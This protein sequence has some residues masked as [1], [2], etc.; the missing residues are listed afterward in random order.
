M[1]DNDSDGE[2]PRAPP[3]K[4]DFGCL[5]QAKLDAVR[6]VA[7]AERD[8]GLSALAIVSAKLDDKLERIRSLQTELRTLKAGK[9]APTQLSA[10]F[11]SIL[12]SPPMVR[13]A[14]ASVSGEPGVELLAQLVGDVRFYN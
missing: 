3:P 4:A 9:Q 1:A 11:A 5:L 13:L 8:A 14:C 6:G 10:E 2:D 7:L 12:H